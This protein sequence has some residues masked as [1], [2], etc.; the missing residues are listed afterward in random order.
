VPKSRPSGAPQPSQIKAWSAISRI[1]ERWASAR[2]RIPEF[3]SFLN[4]YVHFSLTSL[5]CQLIY[6]PVQL[7]LPWKIQM[8]RRHPPSLGL[9]PAGTAVLPAGRGR[10]ATDPLKPAA[11]PGHWIAAFVPLRAIEFLGEL[12]LSAASLL[13][14]QAR[15]PLRDFVRV[16]LQCGGQALVIVT[17]VNM[18]VGA[19]LAFVGALQLVKFGAGIYVADLVGISVTREMA[20]VMTGVVMSGRSGAAF[21]AEL[22]TM[23][24]NEE[25]D[26]LVVLGH[27]PS[28]YLV[29]PRVLA[30]TLMMPL[31]YFYGCAAGLL[32]GLGVSA[33]ML[34]IAASAYIERS[35]GALSLTQ[36]ALGASKSAVFGALVGI[37]GCYCGLHAQRNAAGV[38]AA[39]T[40]AVVSGIVGV[41]ALDAVFAVCANALGI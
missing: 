19:I 28:A 14:G 29:L 13:R 27:S 2:S 3:L 40:G 41:I 22:A 35:A 25:V 1:A 15:F 21:A 33:G 26:A 31:L 23:Q 39:T 24:A 7:F 10:R 17:I 30:L 37:T 18:L 6:R 9:S 12:P 4:R 11:W 16:L 38:G 34:D 36:F 5:A 32:G 20:A 8:R